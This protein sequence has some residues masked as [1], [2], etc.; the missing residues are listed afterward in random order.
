MR[1]V[2]SLNC[3]DSIRLLRPGIRVVSFRHGAERCLNF[4]RGRSPRQSEDCVVVPHIFDPLG[5]TV[6]HRTQSMC[7]SI[8]FLQ[9][10]YYAGMEVGQ[11]LSSGGTP[12]I[13]STRNHRT[14]CPIPP[15][16]LSASL[17]CLQ[18]IVCPRQLCGSPAKNRPISRR[19]S[20]VASHYPSRHPSRGALQCSGI[21]IAI[22]KS[23]PSWPAR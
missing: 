16:I 13:S 21:V 23:L 20:H 12:L 14:F 2:A 15:I 4:H 19:A 6:R 11:R 22:E 1:S 10:P 18:G 7:L 5:A 8:S 17:A 3:A 9:Q